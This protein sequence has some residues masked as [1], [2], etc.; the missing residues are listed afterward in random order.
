M[1][2]GHRSK[3]GGAQAPSPGP[4]QLAAPDTSLPRLQAPIKGTLRGCPGLLVLDASPPWQS[5]RKSVLAAPLC[6]TPRAG[7]RP[8]Q[9]VACTGWGEASS[10]SPRAPAA[11]PARPEC[12]SEMDTPWQPPRLGSFAFFIFRHIPNFSANYS[13]CQLAVWGPGRGYL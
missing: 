11:E 12:C 6:W 9:E 3:T 7:V 10:D 4:S 13:V 5:L 8:I 1:A 2:G